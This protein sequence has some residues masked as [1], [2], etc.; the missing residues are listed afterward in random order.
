M[1]TKEEIIIVLRNN[2][3]DFK[4]LGVISI[5]LFG[6]YAKG[7]QVPDSDV[8]V[9]VELAEPNWNSL[10]TIWNNL[11][12]QLH[13]KVDLVRKGPHLRKSFLHSIEKEII[14]A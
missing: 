2:K 4:D 3:S 10:C 6:S 11:E 1:L 14:Y 9:L 13:K 7:N 8:D 5:G 12:R